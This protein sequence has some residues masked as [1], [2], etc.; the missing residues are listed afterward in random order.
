MFWIAVFVLFDGLGFAVV[1][2][3]GGIDVGDGCFFGW[4]LVLIVCY[5]C[6]GLC[7]LV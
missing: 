4:L 5:G 1:V 6:Y 7:Y 3:F 2:C